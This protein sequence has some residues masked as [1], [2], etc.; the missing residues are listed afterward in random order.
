MIG[1]HSPI[2]DP[3]ILCPDDT[4]LLSLVVP[5]A[6]YWWGQ[7]TGGGNPQSWA[8]HC[9]GDTNILS[10]MDDQSIDLTGN[11]SEQILSTLKIYQG[12]AFMPIQGQPL[13]RIETSPVSRLVYFSSCFMEEDLCLLFGIN[14]DSFVCHMR[15][16]MNEAEFFSLWLKTLQPFYINIKCG[17][18]QITRLLTH[19]CTCPINNTLLEYCANIHF[20]HLLLVYTI[21]KK[22]VNGSGTPRL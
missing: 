5:V 1:P 13:N 14:S 8:Q 4:Y 21:R 11:V 7:F 20:A 18:S 22:L 15:T 10:L 2:S 3:Q 19:S 17:W 9:S 12:A 16:K 6:G